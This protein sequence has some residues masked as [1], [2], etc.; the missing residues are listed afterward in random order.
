[1][2][3]VWDLATGKES[4]AISGHASAV[5]ALAFTPDGKRLA[6][7]GFDRRLRL[8]DARTGR[9][10]AALAGHGGR[11]LALA[12]SSDGS[13]AVTGSMDGLAITWDLSSLESRTRIEH[14]APV[15][16]AGF[17]IDGTRVITTA[18]TSIAFFDLV[19]AKPIT[20]LGG[21]RSP[22]L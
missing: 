17:S 9:E 11:I 7:A 18:T 1:T 16:S 4:P 14:H 3:R 2:V 21:L 6:S 12:I 22:I 13:Q 19:T 15:T 8:S 5:T 10:L 20:A